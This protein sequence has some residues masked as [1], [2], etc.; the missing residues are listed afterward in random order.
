MDLSGCSLILLQVVSLCGATEYYVRPTEPTNTS[1]PGQPCLTINQY[2][3]DS[4]LYFKSNTVFKFLLGTHKLAQ[5]VHIQSIENITL[6]AHIYQPNVQKSYPLLVMWFPDPSSDCI[7]VSKNDLHKE[8]TEQCATLRF[9]NVHNVTIRGISVNVMQQG[10]LG[11]AL[12]QSSVVYI[13]AGITCFQS[14]NTYGLKIKHSK[15]VNIQSTTS[16]KCTYGI[17]VQETSSMQISNTTVSRNT[18]YGLHLNR[19]TYINIH[20]LVAVY[21]LI[22]VFCSSAVNIS[23]ADSIARSNANGGMTINYSINASVSDTLA[24]TNGETGIAVMKSKSVFLRNT[25]AKHNRV[26]GVYIASTFDIKVSNISVDNNSDGLVLNGTTATYIEETSA[27][28]NFISGINLENTTDTHVAY[29]R[30][31]HNSNGVHITSAERTFLTF[32]II[33]ESTL[34]GLTLLYSNN[35]F[36]TNTIVTYSSDGGIIIQYSNNTLMN[37]TSVMHSDGDGILI[38]TT[39]NTTVIHTN[40]NFSI[41]GVMLKKSSNTHIKYIT[42]SYYERTAV[43]VKQARNTLLTNLITGDY[44]VNIAVALENTIN[45]ILTNAS[46]LFSGHYGIYMFMTRNTEILHSNVNNC[47]DLGLYMISSVDTHIENASFLYS[48]SA[49]FIVNKTQNTTI[50]KTTI[51]SGNGT[52]G[53]IMQNTFNSY[54]SDI[55]FVDLRNP[56]NNKSRSQERRVND[57]IYLYHCENT[58]I[59]LNFTKTSSGITLLNSSNAIFIESSFKEN[60]YSSIT[61]DADPVTFPAIILVYSSTVELHQCTF[62]SNSISSIKAIMSAVSLSGNISFL[63]NTAVSGTALILINSIISIGKEAL[64]L[65]RNNVATNTGGV[66]YIANNLQYNPYTHYIV[67]STTCFLKV[68][69]ESMFEKR[70]IFTNNTANKGGDII[71]GGQIALGWN[72]G[73]NCLLNFMNVSSISPTGLSPI[74]SA[75]SRVCICTSNGMPD[76]LTVF[77]SVKQAVYPGQTINISAVVVGQE[78]GTVV[79]SVFAQFLQVSNAPQLD[80]WQYTQDVTKD[81]CRQLHFSIY[82][83]PQESDIV[84]ILTSSQRYISHIMP[85]QK[86]VN[87]TIQLWKS[88]HLYSNEGDKIVRMSMSIQCM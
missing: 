67:P 85:S 58:T 13:E 22:G 19:V 7:Q 28:D 47:S 77:D 79:G 63:N 88:S 72:K 23:I 2:T 45:T 37:H 29:T 46:I 44:S 51:T 65:F 15:L 24:S 80:S 11:I 14:N 64:I 1:C 83:K 84:L 43:D 41:N 9:D 71:Y 87:E 18:V 75:P 30:A 31:V 73:R 3:N 74:S 66:F 78:F 52:Y 76:C 36:I 42:I 68:D 4:D 53:L 32:T 20:S 27:C 62:E 26:Y 56:I 86:E 10:A 81:E 25:T 5:S 48:N 61:S 59:K 35:T 38:G 12:S 16:E 21:N 40:V 54:I 57:A 60:S 50:V 82:S 8:K 17:A 39:A 6:E 49:M 55:T 70:L 34:D 33:E 69:D